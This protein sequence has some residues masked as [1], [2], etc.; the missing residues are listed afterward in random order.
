MTTTVEDEYE[1][2]L[3]RFGAPQG[4][5]A[6]RPEEVEDLRG[7]LPASYLDF[8][9]RTGTGLWMDGYFQLCR[10]LDYR[11]VVTQLFRGDPDIAPEET[12]TIGLSAFGKME[13]W[14]TRH[15]TVRVDPSFNRVICPSITRDRRSKNPERY[16]AI[17]VSSADED[18]LEA[19]DENGNGLFKP[20]LRRDGP[21]PY[22][23][24]YAP[25]L[26]PALGG[27][28]TLD[29]YRIA[30]ASPALSIAVQTAPYALYDTR[31]F[32]ATRTVGTMP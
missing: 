7:I 3:E 19:L 16:L 27:R 26:H 11:D 32:Q 6:V 18:A 12:Y 20:L 5:E 28:R 21:V 24:I 10:P 23:S 29:N 25:R 13:L 17:Q 14:N 22:G 30:A 31:S 4:G 9:V 15:Q 2:I 8:L 1:D